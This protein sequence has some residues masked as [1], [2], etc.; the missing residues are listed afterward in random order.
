ME[1]VFCCPI[2]ALVIMLNSRTNIKGKM[3]KGK[4]PPVAVRPTPDGK[5]QFVF[6]TIVRFFVAVPAE[7]RTLLKWSDA[8]L[9]VFR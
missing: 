6:R 8:S 1:K 2:I 3:K 9:L 5:K 7:R 4:V